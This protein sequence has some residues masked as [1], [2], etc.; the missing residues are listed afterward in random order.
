MRKETVIVTAT[1]KKVKGRKEVKKMKMIVE[2]MKRRR[3]KAVVVKWN[4]QMKR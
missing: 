2:E 3:R 4:L 1:M